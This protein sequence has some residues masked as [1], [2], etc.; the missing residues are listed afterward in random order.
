M[1]GGR[2]GRYGRTGKTFRSAWRGSRIETAIYINIFLQN[3]PWRGFS[4]RSYRVDSAEKITITRQNDE[5]KQFVGRYLPC[6]AEMASWEAGVSY[7]VNKNRRWQFMEHVEDVFK[8]RAE[9]LAEETYEVG[10][11]LRHCHNDKYKSLYRN[12]GDKFKHRNGKTDAHLDGSPHQTRIKQSKSKLNGSFM[13][14]NHLFVKEKEMDV[15]INVFTRNVDWQNYP[16]EQQVVRDF[17]VDLYSKRVRRKKKLSD[18]VKPR[19]KVRTSKA[20][21]REIPSVELFCSETEEIVE[22]SECDNIPTNFTV[23]LGECIKEKVQQKKLN[24]KKSTPATDDLYLRNKGKIIYVS[25]DEKD[26][27]FISEML[28]NVG[29]FLCVK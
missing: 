29:N 21:T 3:Y 23:T 1:E 20:F 28:R 5:M 24:K 2:A 11:G 15:G 6:H 14:D 10:I 13:F 7:S 27:S 12:H 9:E 19:H 8:E 17:A 25:K 16:R 22:S 4:P 18:I 26:E